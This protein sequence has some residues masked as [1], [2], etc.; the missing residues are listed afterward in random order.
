MGGWD[1]VGFNP[2]NP[3]HPKKINSKVDWRMGQNLKD[4]SIFSYN[5]ARD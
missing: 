5:I 3:E 4:Y 1:L 2:P